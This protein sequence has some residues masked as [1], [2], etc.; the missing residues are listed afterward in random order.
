MV[1]KEVKK[2][3]NAYGITSLIL[4]VLGL[5]LFLAPY[6]GIALSITAMA[7]ASKQ[8]KITET[9]LSTAGNIVGI[10]G[11]VINSIALFIFII[12]V[13]IGAVVL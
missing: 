6:F 5:L 3:S 8:K 11:V 12:A 4:G 9:G 7:L 13:I 2:E 1:T 10:I